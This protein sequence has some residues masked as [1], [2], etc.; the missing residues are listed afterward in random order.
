MK[1]KEKTTFFGKTYDSEEGFLK[2][3]GITKY[4]CWRGFRLTPTPNQEE[5]K[6]HFKNRIKGSNK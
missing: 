6:E 4:S 1:K 2:A 5:K 3:M